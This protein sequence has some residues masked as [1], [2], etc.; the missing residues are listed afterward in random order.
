[1]HLRIAF[2]Q[3]YTEHFRSLC[4]PQLHSETFRKYGAFMRWFNF[5]T[6]SSL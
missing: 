2:N 1:M 3:N 5:R 4:A 6:G